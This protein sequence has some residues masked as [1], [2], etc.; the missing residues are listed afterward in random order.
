MDYPNNPAAAPGKGV[1]YGW[2]IVLSCIVILFASSG[3]GF[4]CHGVILDPIRQQYGWSKGIV[5]SAITFFFATMSFTG[6]IIGPQVD[7]FGAK[8]FLVVGALLFSTSYFMLSQINQIWQLFLVYFFMSIGWSGCSLMTVNVLI[9]NWFF[10]KRGLAMSITMTGLSLGGMIIVPL[11]SYLIVSVGFNN[12]ILILSVLFSATIIPIALLFIKAHPSDL[13][14]QPDGLD[15]VLT[16]P[17]PDSPAPAYSTQL[18]TWTHR[19]ALKTK[20]FWSIVIAF[21]FGLCV[22]MAFLVHQV[23]FLSVY[24]GKMGAAAAVSI[25]AGASIVGRL[26]LGTFVDRYDKRYTTMFC[27]LVQGLAVLTLA[28]SQHIAVL[29]LCTFAFGLTMGSMLMMLPLI[30]GECFGMVSFGLIS[31]L[32]GVF[33]TT[34]SAFGP[35]IAG[36]IFDATQSYQVA[37]IFFAVI[38]LTAIGVIRFAIPPD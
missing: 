19:Q 6:L 12:T 7:R 30:T 13:N 33:S 34:G 25:T 10:Q 36:L 35:M 17:E 5:S 21:S 28:F 18:R 22:Q 24:L 38:S 37:F 32:I 1:F 29:Y 14:L 16:Q 4:Y 26:A 27:F 2:W 20:T 11:A 9:T 3:I 8:P 23:S 15:S 31:G